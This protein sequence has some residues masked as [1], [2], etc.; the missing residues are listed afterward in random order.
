MAMHIC[1]SFPVCQDGPVTSGVGERRRS[2]SAEGDW[3]P[4]GPS[5]PTGRALTYSQEMELF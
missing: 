1:A 2:K 5:P 3:R 4:Q